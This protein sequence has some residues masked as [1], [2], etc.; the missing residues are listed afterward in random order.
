VRIGF[1]MKSAE[2]FFGL[3]RDSRAVRVASVGFNNVSQLAGFAKRDGPAYFL[4]RICGVRCVHYPDLAPT[5]EML[6]TTGRGG[7]VGRTTRVA[8]TSSRRPD[9]AR[10]QSIRP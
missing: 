4:E 5:K 6:A 10:R 8:S 9:E 2:R 3:L 1:T 7:A